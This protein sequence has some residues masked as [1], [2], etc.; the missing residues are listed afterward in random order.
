MGSNAAVVKPDVSEEVIKVKV[1]TGFATVA[2]EEELEESTLAKEKTLSIATL[3]KAAD[4]KEGADMKSHLFFFH[5]SSSRKSK[6]C[7]GLTIDSNVS[8]YL[9]EVIRVRLLIQS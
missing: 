6:E 2:D 7:R 8:L 9:F 1:R 4:M 5:Y 3:A